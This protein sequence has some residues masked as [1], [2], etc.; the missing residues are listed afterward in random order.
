MR[1]VYRY[2]AALLVGL[3][4]AGC[5]GELQEPDI[6]ITGLVGS[7]TVDGQPAE[8]TVVEGAPPAENA[9]PV[10][11]AVL[12]AAAINGGS[13]AMT[14]SG[15]E[16][17]SAVVVGVPG[18]QDYFQIVL[19]APVTSARVVVTL[20]QD[21]P[22]GPLEV[23]IAGGVDAATFGP[24]IRRSMTILRVGSGDIQVSVAWNTVADVDLHVVD[25]AGEEIFWSDRRSASG[26]ELD[27]DS[28]AAC[29]S[30]QPR[31]EN[32]V[33]PIGEAPT[34]TYIVRLDYWSSCGALQTDWVLTV[35]VR[36]R[37]PLV[38]SGTFTG[39][40][41]GGGLGSGIEITTFT[42]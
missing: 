2:T 30:D 8:V 31:N 35:W 42:K 29:S 23:F 10:V 20:G 4:A 7:I 9:S 21:A 34:G 40:G 3:A 24:Q 33:W 39:D 27:L 1:T 37:D 38:F 14:V 25:P 22:A 16:T 13:F 5:K 18:V 19:S 6:S 28:N 26:G 32:I 17:F 41:D 15:A 11:D 36:G 12:P